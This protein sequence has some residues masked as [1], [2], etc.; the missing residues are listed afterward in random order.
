MSK[1]TI[2]AVADLGNHVGEAVTIRGW[3]QTVRNQGKIGFIILR[4]LSG[5]A[6]AVV[7][8][9]EETAFAALEGLTHESAVALTGE[10]VKAEQAP[11]GIEVKAK[12]IEVLSLAEP[13]L[14]IQV[15]EKGETEAELNKRL[16]WRW[17]DLRKPEKQL[18]FKVWT[19]MDRAFHA[20][21]TDEG[22]MQVYSPK[23]TSTPSEGGAEVFE[24]AYFDRKAY[25]TQSPQ[26]YKQMAI[27]SGFEKV[28]E[29]GPVFR[30]EPSFTTRHATEFTGYDLE[31]AYVTSHHDVMDTQE[32]LLVAM[33]AAVEKEHGDEIEK[34]YGQ[35][36]IVPKT[37]FP[38]VSMA[39]AK[40]LLAK[41]KIPIHGEGD[42]NPE[43]ERA[44]SA[45]IEK[46]HGHQWVFV[47]D[48]PVAVR[49]FYHMRHADNPKLTKSYDLLY[50]GL[51]VTT[52][53]QREHRHDVLVEQAK[54]KGMDVEQLQFYLNFF[55][56]G[57]PP[58][59]G[60][61]MGPNRLL[62]R[63][64][65]LPSLREAMFIYRGPH[66]LTP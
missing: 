55:R 5:S 22:F 10:V 25:L 66:R 13:E 26:F 48:Y 28:F 37:P 39:E 60:L 6:Q 49:P 41:A 7:L 19:V 29:V 46:E 3:V 35:K 11:G 16:D 4:D 24:V 59:G 63:L 36:A 34:T 18:I 15:Y 31:M 65:D 50:K 9:A 44:L 14:P 23:L 43:E 42:L 32:K 27:A 20:H 21:L 47:T 45:M 53:A 56:Y 57:C 30:A 58:H 54:E 40:K 62:M 1:P 51:E 33:L 2:V 52:G 38:R 64:L 17:L 61:G 8:K 12:E